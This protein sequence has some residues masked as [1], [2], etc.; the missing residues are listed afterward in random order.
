MIEDKAVLN[1]YWLY[2]DNLIDKDTFYATIEKIKQSMTNTIPTTN[3]TTLIT[4]GQK[5]YISRLKMEGKIPQSQT[6]DIS[7]AEAQILIHNAVN[8]TPKKDVEMRE[9]LFKEVDDY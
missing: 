9:D 6:L 5:N 2:K 4:Q 8:V 3:T 7:K 1:A